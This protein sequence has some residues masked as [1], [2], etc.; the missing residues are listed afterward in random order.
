[1]VVWPSARSVLRTTASPSQTWWAAGLLHDL[2][3]QVEKAADKHGLLTKQWLTEAGMNEE[4]VHSMIVH[5]EGLGMPRA[6][7]FEHLLAAAETL[8]GLVRAV[9]L[10]YPD[11]K[12]APVKPKSVTKRIKNKRFA[13]KVNRVNIRECDLAGVSAADLVAT[14]LES[15]KSVADEIGL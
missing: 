2:D 15:M 13:A 7:P 3:F 9:A 11:K 6:T 14:T 1:M 5:N 12:I 4:L 8:T 10:I